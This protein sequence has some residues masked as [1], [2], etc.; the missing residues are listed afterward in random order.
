MRFL[1]RPARP[2]LASSV[3]LLLVASPAMALS[4]GDIAF[5][6]YQS[7]TP[8]RYS[9]VALVDIPPSEEIKFTD[10]GWLAAGGFRPVS[11][12]HLTLPTI[13]LV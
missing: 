8:D 6:S 12:T 3:L 4:S 5:V 7:D 10:N 1:A 11:Y 2:T 13:L 9:F